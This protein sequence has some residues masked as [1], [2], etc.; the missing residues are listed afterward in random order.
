MYKFFGMTPVDEGSWP[1]RCGAGGTGFADPEGNAGPV[2]Y[3]EE[4]TGLGAL[5]TSLLI[6]GTGLISSYVLLNGLLCRCSALLGGD[7][8]LEEP[9]ILSGDL[10]LI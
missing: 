8:P 10:R 2:M 5:L 1:I 3:G 7:R 9:K 6:Y 4:L